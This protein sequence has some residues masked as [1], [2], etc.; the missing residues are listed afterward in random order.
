MCAVLTWMRYILVGYKLCFSSFQLP[1][2]I[3]NLAMEDLDESFSELYI[4]SG[5][6]DGVHRAVHIPQ[7]RES[8]IH[9]RRNL[10]CGAVGVQYMSDE[11]R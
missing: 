7:P 11:K 3:P 1:A 5:V 8:V 2:Q 10:A 9:L 6:Y 4:E